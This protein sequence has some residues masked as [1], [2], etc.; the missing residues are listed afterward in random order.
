MG[1]QTSHHFNPLDSDAT[2]WGFWLDNNRSHLGSA[3]LLLV[4]VVQPARVS[5][6]DFASPS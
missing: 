4:S 6:S 3:R 5:R 2:L 1:S